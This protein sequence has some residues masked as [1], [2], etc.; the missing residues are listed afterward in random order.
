M[1]ICVFISVFHFMCHF[2]LLLLFYHFLFYFCF[3]GSEQF[4]QILICDQNN[5]IKLIIGGYR[6]D[7]QEVSLLFN[8]RK[9][10]RREK[11]KGEKTFVR[12]DLTC[13]DSPVISPSLSLSLSPPLPPFIPPFPFPSS[14]R[15]KN[16]D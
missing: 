14:N 11:R 6:E 3:F 9:L 16:W 7:K 13:V 5:R 4:K 2:I 15:Q 8:K 12:L 10:T 1:F